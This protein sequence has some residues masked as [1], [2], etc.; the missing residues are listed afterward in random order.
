[1]VKN[2]G[3]WL[4]YDDENVEPVDE[5]DIPRY[6]GDYP[7]G[8]GYVLFYQAV[9]LDPV[10]LGLEKAPP[11]HVAEP[12]SMVIPPS[13]NMEVD[14][15]EPLASPTFSTNIP[16]LDVEPVP[17]GVAAANMSAK[18]KV[19]AALADYQT[20]VRRQ[21]S[22]S[23]SREQ[24]RSIPPSRQPTSSMPPSR[25]GTTDERRTPSFRRD[26]SPSPSRENDSYPTSTL[27]YDR[28]IGSLSKSQNTGGNKW[29]SKFGV[30]KDGKNK[31]TSFY[32]NSDRPSSSGTNA[33]GTS[34]AMSPSYTGGNGVPTRQRTTSNADLSGTSAGTSMFGMSPQAGTTVLPGNGTPSGVSRHTTPQAMPSSGN[35]SSS[36][37]SSVTTSSSDGGS[38]LHR[39]VQASPPSVPVQSIPIAQATSPSARP[40]MKSNFSNFAGLG[41][42]S[43]KKE[44][45]KR[46]RQTSGGSLTRRLSM[47]PGSLTRSSSAAFKSMLGGGKK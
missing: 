2:E 33:S 29:L 22:M 44:E 42:S 25:Q 12:E 19:E 34:G 23:Q 18:A 27:D 10:S 31:R 39:P 17:V 30:S 6:F 8:A 46:D 43:E 16:M 21:P 32:G 3:R 38:A 1:V 36:F 4:L 28:G 24:P 11:V 14:P 9:D 47:K 40:E 7:A 13:A 15:I 20:S 41:R 37:M 26:P 5:A 45:D 35:M